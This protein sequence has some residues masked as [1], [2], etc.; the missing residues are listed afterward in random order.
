MAAINL[1]SWTHQ[2]RRP[3]RDVYLT[4]PEILRALGP[5]DLDPCACDEP[6]PWPTAAVHYTFRDNGLRQPWPRQ[7]RVWCNP[8]FG[9]AAAWLERLAAHGN[10]V[11]LLFA[12]TETAAFV[13]HVWGTAGAVLFLAGRPHFYTPAGER[14]RGGCG[15]PCLLA[16]YGGANVTALRNCRL[17]G[18]LCERWALTGG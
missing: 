3:Y 17:P 2:R 8:P 4:P 12:R 6:R 9:T 18:A 14:L 16:A 10:G 5:F 13:R 15:G 7:C 1:G 11:A